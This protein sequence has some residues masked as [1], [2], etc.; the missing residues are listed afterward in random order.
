MAFDDL[1]ALELATG[2]CRAQRRT[3]AIKKSAEMQEACVSVTKLLRFRNHAAIVLLALGG[4][5]SL[6][7]AYSTGPPDGRAGDPPANETCKD[8]GCHNSFPLNGGDGNLALQGLPTTY[9]PDSVYVLQVVLNDPGQMRWGF[10]A[11]VIRPGFGNQAGVLAPADSALVQVSEG[12]GDLRDY[13]MHTEAGTFPG[14][15]GGNTWDILWTAPG[16]GSGTAHFYVAGNAA[17]NSELPAGDYIYTFNVAVSEESAA[18]ADE[19]LEV[20]DGIALRAVPNPT[21]AGT[22]IHFRL[23]HASS[24]NL[25][26][27]DSAG[28]QVRRWNVPWTEPGERALYWDGRDDQGRAVAGGAYYYVLTAGS[29]RET[30]RV[31][32]VR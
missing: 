29:G 27:V 8:V 16:L 22:T 10:E 30:Q 7:E 6:S 31:I 13:I 19:P 23:S 18:N 17:N 25:I 2:I 9:V 1:Y 20:A 3:G 28:R 21:M 32:V 12:L 15:G 24:A 14:Q 26:V 5:P 11:T 4:A